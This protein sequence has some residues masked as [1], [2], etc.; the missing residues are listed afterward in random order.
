MQCKRVKLGY[1]FQLFVLDYHCETAQKTSKTAIHC[2]KIETFL[3]D[4]LV[5]K[6]SIF[7]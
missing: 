6:Q 4:S 2:V 5:F 1:N 7:V 3:S